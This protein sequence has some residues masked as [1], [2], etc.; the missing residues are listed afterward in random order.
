LGQSW[1]KVWHLI[2]KSEPKLMMA[3]AVIKPYQLSPSDQTIEYSPYGSEKWYF[4]V[5]LAPAGP[6]VPSHANFC[7]KVG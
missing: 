6:L 2:I 3:M 5:M 1:L 4:N 7:A